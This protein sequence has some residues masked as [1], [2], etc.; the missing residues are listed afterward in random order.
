MDKT[1]QLK[2]EC[3]GSLTV[4]FCLCIYSAIAKP[5]GQSL[6]T[7]YTAVLG[8]CQSLQQQVHA[9]VLQIDAI[10]SQAKASVVNVNDT[11]SFDAVTLVFQH[12]SAS[13]ANATDFGKLQVTR[14][15]PTVVE[16]RDAISDIVFGIV[17]ALQA[18]VA[19]LSTAIEESLDFFNTSEIVKGL[20]ALLVEGLLAL[21][22]GVLKPLLGLPFG[23]QLRSL[24]NSII[25]LIS[26]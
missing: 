21:I 22:D 15:R 18:I 13:I 6:K 1:F 5:F 11:A 26:L 8:V 2:I 25:K 3:E 4:R 17:G 16:S 10:L 9:D 7:S 19:D 20:A 14:A 24:I 12:M 23:E